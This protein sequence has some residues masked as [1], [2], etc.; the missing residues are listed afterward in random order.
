L[1]ASNGTSSR[2]APRAKRQAANGDSYSRADDRFH[3]TGASLNLDAR[4]HAYRKDIADIG[5]AGLIFA[6]HY[7]RPLVRGCGAS[8][9]LVRSGPTEDSGAVSELLPGEDFAVLEYAGGRAWGYCRTDHVTGYVEA[10]ALTDQEEATHIVCERSAP[11]TAEAALGATILASLPMGSRLQGHEQGAFLA[12]EYGLVPLCHV[13][14]L[15]E[16]ESDPVLVAERLLGAPF[17][18][19]GRGGEGI[20]ATGLVQLA[21]GLCGIK[22]PRL[23]DQQRLLGT[24]VAPGAP[25]RRGDVVSFGYGVGL[26]V[27]DLLLIHASAEAGKV[28]VEPLISIDAAMEYRRV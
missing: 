15:D 19:G 13:R 18:T 28:V 26:M 25:L 8:P 2:I 5:L 14:G 20:D 4:V 10:I 6:P 16:Q 11:V 22:A 7:A 17:L 24:P 23:A 21:L 1:K 12:T 3:L 27:D 9:A